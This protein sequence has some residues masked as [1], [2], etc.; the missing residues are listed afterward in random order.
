MKSLELTEDEA[1]ALALGETRL[2]DAR[3]REAHLR[4]TAPILPAPDLGPGFPGRQYPGLDLDFVT[5]LTRGSW[6]RE[7]QRHKG[8]ISL[9]R[10]SDVGC[11]FVLKF[12]C[13]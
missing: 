10:V 8:N 11:A 6:K 3:E 13:P 12:C 4:H 1:D 7:S 5:Y 9:L 2:S